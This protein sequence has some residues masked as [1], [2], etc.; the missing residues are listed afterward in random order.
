MSGAALIAAVKYICVG[1]PQWEVCG[2][3][4]VGVIAW[5]RKAV[6]GWSS[7]DCCSKLCVWGERG[8]CVYGYVGMGVGV[9]TWVRKAVCGWGSLDCCRKVCVC[10]GRGRVCVNAWVWV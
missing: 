7:L 3:D 2:C 10:G 4:Y 9:I 6:C 5:V 8:E 1:E